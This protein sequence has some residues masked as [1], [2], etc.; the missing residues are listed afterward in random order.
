MEDNRLIISGERREEKTEKEKNWIHT[1]RS[2]GAFY[3]SLRLPKSV[4]ENKIQANF[5]N[6]VLS[7]QLPKTERSKPK[8]IEIK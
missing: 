1:E 7:V 5:R 6:G 8:H 3:R 2:F 4:D